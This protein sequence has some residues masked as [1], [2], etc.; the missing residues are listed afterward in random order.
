MKRAI[1][2]LAALALIGGCDG[3]SGGS[4]AG[5]IGSVPTPTPTPPAPTPTPTSRPPSPG[6]I[7]SVQLRGN[8]APV[9]SPTV[10]DDGDT[11]YVFSTG[12]LGHPD[13]LLPMR[14]LWALNMRWHGAT[15]AA[16]PAW[17]L[18]AVPRASTM[19][20]PSIVKRNGEYRLYYSVSTAG[21]TQSV[22]G[23]TVTNMLNPD[24]PASGWSDRGMVLLSR[25]GSL[26]TIDPAV[27]ADIDGRDWMA[28]VDGDTI[29]LAEL[30]PAT[31]LQRAGDSIL[32][33]AT[34]AADR[35][36]E[37]PFLMRHGDYYYLFA[38]TGTC[39]QGLASGSG[40]TVGRSR[41]ITGPY[42]DK[43]GRSMLEGGGSPYYGMG[44]YDGF[45]YLG[46][47]HIE[48]FHSGSQDLVSYHGYDTEQ[49]GAATIRMTPLGWDENGWPFS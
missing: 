37:A 49:N 9:E 42:L 38:S 43:E 45:R 1:I 29:K 26:R 4:N 33:L 6:P 7:G 22:I 13:G 31:G 28:F 10:L 27:F 24:A 40:M 41:T 15:Q 14:T 47:G 17:A 34:K 3:D 25:G 19:G 12:T 23:L 11:F 8:L 44:R 30:D 2:P 48:I 20:S 35:S 16:I 46:L 39:C 21:R 36:L 5:P 32:L 18:A